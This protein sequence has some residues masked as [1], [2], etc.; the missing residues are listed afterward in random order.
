MKI[1]GDKPHLIQTYVKKIGEGER[2]AQGK[3]PNRRSSTVD[4]VDLSNEARQR[5]L[6][7]I[8]ELLEEVPDVR[9]DRVAAAREAIENETYEVKGKEIAKKMIKESIDEF[10]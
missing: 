3:E 9:H 2:V 6:T 7:E 4:K 8:K 10:V 5:K 1:S